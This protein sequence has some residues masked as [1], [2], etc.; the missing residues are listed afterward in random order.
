[1]SALIAS[2]MLFFV[3]SV[4]L[5]VMGFRFWVQPQTAMERVMGEVEVQQQTIRDPSLNFR[6]LLTRVGNIVPANPTD[7]GIL[8][9]RLLAAGIRNPRAL[10]LLYGV[11]VILAAV[12]TSVTVG[13]LFGF[14]MQDEM[15]PFQILAAAGLGWAGPNFMVF[16][17]ASKRQL[18]IKRGLPN[19]LDMLVICVE[20]GLGLDQ[21]LM[22]V[23]KELRLAHPEITDEFA[24]LNLEIRAGKR[25]TEALHNLGERVG[26]DELK[27]MVSVLV[28]ADKFGTS[29]SQTLRNFSDFMRVQTRQEAE[30]KAAK[31]GVKLVFPIFFFILPSL[32]FVTV[33]PMMVRVMRDFLPQIMGS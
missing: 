15:A 20:S 18:E 11:K 25:R 19:A 16:R 29:I 9:K 26:V 8:Q 6:D 21:A 32:F 4:V 7:V 28:Q 27:K 17:M 13:V 10:R 14:S 12:F 22:Q 33:G 24:V 2:I 3:I 30:E 5:S 31:I 1:M 23:S